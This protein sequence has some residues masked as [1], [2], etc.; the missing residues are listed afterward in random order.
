MR[1]RRS[2][3][4]SRPRAPASAQ[5]PR[6]I[7]ELDRFSAASLERWADVSGDL[8]ELH[9]SL[10]F[11][12]EPGR[13]RYRSELIDALKVCDPVQV[14]LSNWCRIV[15]YRYSLAPLSCAGSLQYIGGRFN[16]G[17]ELDGGT[18]AA[19]P[20]LYLA[21]DFET[22]FRE[23]FQRASDTSENGLS[24]QEMAL[25]PGASMSCVIVHGSLTNVFDLT[26]LTSLAP[27]AK[28][29]GKISMPSKAVKLK[30]KLKIAEGGVRPVKTAKQAYDAVLKFNWR[31]APV[32]FGL[33]SPSQILGE[34]VRAAGFEAILFQSSKGPGKCLAVFPDN[35]FDGSFINLTDT[36]PDG[37]THRRLDATSA[38]ELAGWDSVPHQL[39]AR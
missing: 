25:E 29:F 31:I 4:P 13:R 15:T 7:E 39:R 6:G 20:A 19:W 10:Y 8:D 21:E 32:Q 12:M 37:V 16:A 17:T 22:A 36:P 35:L 24:P 26:S 1:S 28:V 23:K 9:D 18:L 38:G 27:I 3:I 11:G 14:P 33:P 30:K 5:G 2:N 34:L